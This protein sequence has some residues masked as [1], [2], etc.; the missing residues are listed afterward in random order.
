MHARRRYNHTAALLVRVKR[1]DALNGPQQKDGSI[2]GTYRF[3]A[4]DRRH[5][6]TLTPFQNP[7]MTIKALFC[8]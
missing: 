4:A 1:G 7:T 3:T 2:G 6:L 5:A 8:T